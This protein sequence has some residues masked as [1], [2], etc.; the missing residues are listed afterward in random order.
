MGALR[1]FLSYS[2]YDAGVVL[3]IASELRALGLNPVWDQA[4]VP[5]SP[6]TDFIKEKIATAHVFVPILSKA[7]QQSAWVHQEIGFAIGIDIPV[8][9]VAIGVLPA[10]LLAGLQ[11][12]TLREDLADLS[13]KLK[14]IDFRSLVLSGGLEPELQRLGI[15][16]EL[17]NAPEERARMLVTFAQRAPEHGVVRQRALFSSFSIPREDPADPVWTAIDHPRNRSEFYRQRLRREREV[18]EEHAGRCGCQLILH[19]FGL[20]TD[21][22]E[23]QR[24]RLRQL[25]G[26]LEK[27][28]D[29][30]TR[31]AIS[32]SGLKESLILVGDWSGARSLLP[33]AR[34]DYR[35]TLFCRHAPTVLRW[36]VEFD[37]EIESLLARSSIRP[38]ESREAALEALT[39]SLRNR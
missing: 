24:E 20:A 11:A 3:T 34:S 7:S 36:V 5:G 35:Q 30:T 12:V 17:A 21:D 29:E 38:E 39:V 16:S 28:P 14:R 2:H 9:P 26:F 15:N 32:H 23:S 33:P 1:V 6:F 27:Q 8:L 19:P 37:R 18:M 31:V 22:G 25:I 4:V 13:E 10:E